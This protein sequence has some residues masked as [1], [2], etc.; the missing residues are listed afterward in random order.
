MPNPLQRFSEPHLESDRSAE[1]PSPNFHQAPSH[2]YHVLMALLLGGQTVVRILR[3]QVRSRRVMDHLIEAGPGAF[4]PVVMTNGFAG[5]I[6]ALQTARE[7]ERFGTLTVL[8]GAFASG[9]CRELAPI[10]TAAVLAGQVGCA[11]AAEIGSMNITEQI[12][13]LRMLRT[14]PIAYLVVPRVV[15]CCIMLPLLTVMGITLGVGCGLWAVQQFYAVVG[16]DFLQSI[17]AAIAPADVGMVMLKAALF[18]G[19]VALV[20]CAWGLTTTSSQGLGRAT[21][22]AVV[23]AWVCLFIIDFGLTVLGQWLN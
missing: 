2:L 3:R 21:K 14:D 8:G 22:A 12:D 19:M 10:L 20:S 6:F 11:F 17:Q 18:G 9:F 5:M 15:A 7:L 4:L 16:S 1:S 23:T 13:A